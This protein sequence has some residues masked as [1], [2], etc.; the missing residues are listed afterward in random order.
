MR[1][2]RKSL[3]TDDGDDG[4]GKSAFG[5][6]GLSPGDRPAYKPPG[7]AF[8]RKEHLPRTRTRFYA[9]L[10]SL[11]HLHLCSQTMRMGRDDSIASCPGGRLNLCVKLVWGKEREVDVAAAVEDAWILTVSRFP[12]RQT[13]KQSPLL[14]PEAT[15]QMCGA[16]G[17]VA[18]LL[19]RS[20]GQEVEEAGRLA[21]LVACRPPRSP[22]RLNGPS[23]HL[24][25]FAVSHRGHS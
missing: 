22:R 12:Q 15:P 18:Y 3:L 11:G 10:V 2:T 8:Q 17:E 5:C 16:D 14:P 25:H 13:R 6:W 4:V 23:F 24:K 9:V 21:R 20:Y 19:E 1:T 7:N